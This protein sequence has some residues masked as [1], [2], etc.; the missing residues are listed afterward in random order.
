MYKFNKFVQLAKVDEKTRTVTG[1]AIREELDRAGEIFDYAE[2]KPLFEQW[3]GDVAKATDGKSLGNVREMHQ[4]SA[5]GKVSQMIFNDTDKSLAISVKVV[6]DDA[7]RKVQEGVYSGFSV[8][9]DYA[10]KWKDGN[11]T[12]YAAQPS[13]VSLVDFPCVPSATFTVEKVDGAQELRKFKNSEGAAQE[14]SSPTAPTVTTAATAA[15]SEP[16]TLNGAADAPQ[17]AVQEQDGKVA[18]VPVETT[19]TDSAGATPVASSEPAT[20]DPAATS[21]ASA[22]PPT[23]PTDASAQ[24]VAKAAGLS[25]K[26]RAPT[27]LDT[28]RA[29]VILRKQDSYATL[30]STAGELIGAPLQKGLWDVGRLADLLCSLGCMTH[31]AQSETE[32]EGDGSP[33]PAQ[34][35]GAA[36]AVAAALVAMTQEETDELLQGLADRIETPADVMA[37]AASSE[38]LQKLANA[39]KDRTEMRQRL[40]KMEAE[41]VEAAQII[42]RLRGLAKN[43]LHLSE[44][45]DEMVGSSTMEPLVKAVQDPAT[46]KENAAATAIKK[47]H[48]GV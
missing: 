3:S 5:V 8:G 29:Q 46:G 39:M 40:V 35:L 47:I 15:P 12:R 43:Q 18:A 17:G 42:T 2:S 24:K 11:A 21:N 37:L 34:L 9:G 25:V 36:R 23:T 28:L 45:G 19:G 30:V 16:S 32:W 33:L 4:P 26:K 10:R 14:P 22:A 13:E 27:L 44:K 1:I 31:D 38:G 48:A 6:D 7:W 41:V 20:S